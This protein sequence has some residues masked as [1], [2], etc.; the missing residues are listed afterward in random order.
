MGDVVNRLLE[1][2]VVE[3]K[4]LEKRRVLDAAEIRQVV[5]QRR[6]HEQR[7]LRGD[8]QPQQYLDY[9]EYEKALQRLIQRRCRKK[10]VHPKVSAKLDGLWRRRVIYLFNRTLRRFPADEQL[11][12]EFLRH[13]ATTGSTR[14]TSRI[15]S[16]ALAVLP[17]SEKLW[18]A[19]FSWH[20]DHSPDSSHARSIA[21]TAMRM[22]PTS[23]LIYKAYFD[24][25]VA[26]FVKLFTRRKTLGLLGDNARQDPTEVG[27]GKH[28]D[29]LLALAQETDFWKGAVPLAVFKQ[30]TENVDLRQEFNDENGNEA[31]TRARYFAS[32]LNFVNTVPYCIP[33]LAAQLRAILLQNFAGSA[34]VHA[35]V[36]E[37]VRRDEIAQGLSPVLAI[38][39][40][41]EHFKASLVKHA[42]S[43]LYEEF[44]EFIQ[45]FSAPQHGAADVLP[46][47]RAL[48]QEASDKHGFD[49]IH[50]SGLMLETTEECDA[51]EKERLR[52]IAENEL[53][54][55]LD[56]WSPESFRLS[57]NGVHTHVEVTTILER[58]KA[59]LGAIPPSLP[60]SLCTRLR[61][62]LRVLCS[63]LHHAAREFSSQCELVR[64]W[65][66][67]ELRSQL[68]SNAQAAVD[69]GD[70]DV[71]FINV[72]HHVAGN[73]LSSTATEAVLLGAL[74]LLRNQENLE[75]PRI[76]E[77]TLRKLTLQVYDELF[78]LLPRS[79]ENPALSVDYIILLRKSGQ[80]VRAHQLYRSALRCA[81]NAA[82]FEERLC[83][84]DA[85][86]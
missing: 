83:A 79:V 45:R 14:A 82:L 51:K 61:D 24:L 1:K 2:G 80:A 28:E 26:F 15:F 66:E 56:Q 5:R 44:I 68:S 10:S 52:H 50:V 43:D 49:N 18:V 34:A 54:E 4:L 57:R 71:S 72:V 55:S 77:A 11:W 36:A 74:E 84:A 27:N 73:S 33:E 19:S 41:V 32:Y 23:A 42:S 25:E 30:A 58:W 64:A 29:E 53:R 22:L 47:V 67:W 46:D 9:V 60:A 16:R 40:G 75:S 38:Q 76:V 6:G 65:L 39:R 59:H 69:G 86:R 31:G 78:R 37:S 7:L 20:M 3:L 62:A 35:A 17:L 21:L 8:V 13:C 48:V 85:H 81:A 63:G 70:G 12:L